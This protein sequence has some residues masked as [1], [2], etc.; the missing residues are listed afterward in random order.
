MRRG[1]VKLSV[2][3]PVAKAQLTQG[4]SHRVMDSKR[5]KLLEKARRL[6]LL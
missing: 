5:R 2:S 4:K 1:D 3:N 6:E